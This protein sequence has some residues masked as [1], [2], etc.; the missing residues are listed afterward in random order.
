MKVL[1]SVKECGVVAHERPES[2]TSQYGDCYQKR[3]CS[4][5]FPLFKIFMIQNSHC[6][7]FEVVSFKCSN[8][9]GKGVKSISHFSEFFMIL[10]P[11]SYERGDKWALKF[12]NRVLLIY[13][14]SFWKIRG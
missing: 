5:I 13:G 2:H 3:T 1:R 9:D 4:Q 10:E 6:Y 8:P 12:M 11:L 14:V 7:I